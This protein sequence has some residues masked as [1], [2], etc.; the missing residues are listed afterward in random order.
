MGSPIGTTS[1]SKG[2]KEFNSD[3]NLPN[4]LIISFFLHMLVIGI[5][6]ESL[7][8]STLGPRSPSIEAV[9]QWK[10]ARH[11]EPHGIAMDTSPHASAQLEA[12]GER[13][14]IRGG[15]GQNPLAP[16]QQLSARKEGS[17]DPVPEETPPSLVKI[18]EDGLNGLDERGNGGG[19]LVARVTVSRQGRATHIKIMHSSLPPKIEEQVVSR[20]HWAR[21][22][23][24][25]KDGHPV[26]GVMFLEVNVS[27]NANF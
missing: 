4:A 14:Y 10:S 20:L 24:G 17:T 25:E 11:N 16:S 6:P 8:V 26:E 21:Y 18:D 7:F 5:A 2:R 15:E 3:T 23:P 27:L 19:G 1:G 22:R 9:I 12:N 13:K